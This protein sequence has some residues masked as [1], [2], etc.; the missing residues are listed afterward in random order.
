[1]MTP[2]NIELLTA[3]LLELSYVLD[4]IASEKGDTDQ[5]YLELS[6]VEEKLETIINRYKEK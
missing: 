1:M 5:L 2:T 6:S 4:Y 3:A